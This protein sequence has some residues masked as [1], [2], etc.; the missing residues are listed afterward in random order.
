MIEYKFNTKNNKEIKIQ[1]DKDII[2]I[3][4]EQESKK[5]NTNKYNLS[6]T[7]FKTINVAKISYVKVDTKVKRENKIIS[8]TTLVFGIILLILAFIAKNSPAI[9]SIFIIFSLICIIIGIYTTSS[10]EIKTES[11]FKIEDENQ[12]VLYQKQLNL[13]KEKIEEIILKIRKFQE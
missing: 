6:I 13:T 8:F 5:D 4:E 2:N 10:K 1:I 12:N 9:G 7:N 11:H 3:I